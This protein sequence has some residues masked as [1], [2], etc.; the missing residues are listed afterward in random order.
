MRIL[1]NLIKDFFSLETIQLIGILM[2]LFCGLLYYYVSA[3]EAERGRCETPVYAAE[4][5]HCERYLKH[6]RG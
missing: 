6:D 1:I 5:P 4:N 2:L 3:N